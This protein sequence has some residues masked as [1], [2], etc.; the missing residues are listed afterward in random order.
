MKMVKSR[1]FFVWGG[2]AIIMALMGLVSSCYQPVTIPVSTELPTT[3]D[4]TSAVSTTDAYTLVITGLVNT[5]L[6]LTYDSILEYPTTS[7]DLLLVCPGFFQE[8]H[9][10]TGIAVST[11][12][13]E[14]GIKPEATKV[15]FHAVDRYKREFSLEDVL[16]GGFFLAHTVDGR[17]LRKEE[18]YPLRLVVSGNAGSD[19]VRWVNNIE[20]T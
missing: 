6:S 15:V 16:Q 9:E 2:L 19:W 10:W 18:G 17:T 12:L 11:L 5:P 7:Q 20:I 14:A 4:S 13:T 1:Y 8:R 3:D